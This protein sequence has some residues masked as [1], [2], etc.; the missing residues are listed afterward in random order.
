MEN[1]K[2][3]Q[4]ILGKNDGR[5]EAKI[6]EFE[7]LFYDLDNIYEKVTDPFNFL[8]LGRKG[9]GK[10][11]L[12]ELIKK[13]NNTQ[14]SICNIVNYNK[15]NL[16]YFKE[17]KS[18]TDM[19]ADEYLAVWE[20]VILI[21]LSKIVV[22]DLNSLKNST[23]KK[24]SNFLEQNGFGLELDSYK[25]IEITKKNQIDGNFNIKIAKFGE[26]D[27]IIE[28]QVI[29]TFIECLEPLKEILCKLFKENFK[30]EII[31]IYDELDTKFTND[32]DYKNLIISLIKKTGELNEFFYDKNIKIKIMVFLREDIFNLL[33]DYDLNKIKEDNSVKIDWGR[34]EESSPLVEMIMKKI[35]HSYPSLSK[36]ITEEIIK[37]IFPKIKYN[38][39][40]NGNK[41]IKYINAF[42]Y[43]LRR[44]FLRPRD[45]ITFLNKIIDINKNA[46]KFYDN[47]VKKAEKSY[48]EYLVN[49]I[50][51][52]M[53][54][55][56]EDE[57]ID[58]ILSLL[59]TFSKRYFF[60]S[61]LENFYKTT[62]KEN[63]EIDLK[64]CITLL[65]NL[66]VLGNHY[67]DNK[68]GV[69]FYKYNYRE[70]NIE[71]NFDQTFVLHEGFTKY[72]IL[73]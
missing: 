13:R 72:F 26:N 34:N 59:R 15:F 8:V 67:I 73:K 41:S 10:T 64:K 43:Y 50:R 17:L 42:E 23:L 31:L 6:K 44:T 69:K 12:A 45:L 58:Y 14:N 39:Y 55:H 47:L 27:E 70:Q 30:K 38:Y 54:G 29:T 60:Y 49:E 28:K 57:E 48:S 18:E 62:K 1:F 56:L 61:D 65:F 53:K 71:I 16:T 66:S 2:L 36:K 51:N 9:T 3:G 4:I 37:L 19:K 11:L 40:N 20:W 22:R 7:N 24:L 32:V 52:E 33:N 63:I 25:T 5:N 68:R 46:D 21:E 35:K